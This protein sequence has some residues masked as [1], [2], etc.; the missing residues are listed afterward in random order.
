MKS[1]GL[2]ANA[3]RS[4]SEMSS[5]TATLAEAERAYL[6]PCLDMANLAQ[7]ELPALVT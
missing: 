3:Q 4:G 2:T 7:A 5:P 6:W 1:C